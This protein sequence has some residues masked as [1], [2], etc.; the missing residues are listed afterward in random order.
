MCRIKIQ[1]FI[2]VDASI[3]SIKES[4]FQ[5]LCMYS[6]IIVSFY[7]KS[8]FMFLRVLIFELKKYFRDLNER[9]SL[10]LSVFLIA[11]LHVINYCACK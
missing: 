8:W 2:G 4:G 11:Y 9:L 3:G 6:E 1:C 7:W 10:C 5:C